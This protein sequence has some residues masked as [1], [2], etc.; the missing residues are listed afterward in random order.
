MVIKLPFCRLISISLWAWAAEAPGGFRLRSC[1]L[2]AIRS[3]LSARSSDAPRLHVDCTGAET[4]FAV[5]VGQDNR[6]F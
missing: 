6:N 2:P 5:D 4:V 1:W 3:E